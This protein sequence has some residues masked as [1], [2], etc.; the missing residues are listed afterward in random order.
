MD[1]AHPELGEYISPQMV[2]HLGG[3]QEI[4]FIGFL[5]EGI[6]QEYLSPPLDLLFYQPVNLGPRPL[7]IEPRLHGNPSRWKFIDYRD[8]QIPVEGEGQGSWDRGGGHH[9]H[10][11]V[12]PL[13][14]QRCPLDDAELMLFIDDH[15]AEPVKMDVLLNEGVRPY[16]DMLLARGDGMQNLLPF[17]TFYAAGQQ[18]RLNSQWRNDPS[19]IQEMLLR[20]NLRGNHEGRLV[21]IFHRDKGRHQGYNGLSAPHVTLK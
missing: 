14:P 9:Q 21:A 18:H 12:C 13:P 20:Q 5:D 10:I 15:Q 19:D 7:V 1:Q 8:G 17:R 2:G 11:G 4:H 3:I 6:Y 16:N